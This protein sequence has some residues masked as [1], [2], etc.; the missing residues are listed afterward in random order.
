MADPDANQ[1]EPAG[2]NPINPS[3]HSE[4]HD[5]RFGRL[6]LII[7]ILLCIGIGDLCLVWI[8]F[9]EQE[10]KEQAAKQSQ[11][12]LAE[13][14]GAGLPMPPRLEQIDRESGSTTNSFCPRTG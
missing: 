8:F 13:T 12:P 1:T 10:K 9:G 5:I 2:N 4:S 14:S 6:V 3:V 7:V 11:Y